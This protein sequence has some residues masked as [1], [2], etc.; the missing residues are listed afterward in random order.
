MLVGISKNKFMKEVKSLIFRN[1]TKT[2]NVFSRQFFNY[3]LDNSLL[4]YYSDFSRNWGDF[5]N[6]TLINELQEKEVVS[7][8]RIYNI[9]KKPAVFGIGSILN[10]NLENAVIWGSGFI[11]YPQQVQKPPKE[12]LA[13][14]GKLTAGYFEKMGVPHN[15]VYGD[16]ALLLPT[17]YN[18]VKEKKF[19]LG[20]VPH[21]TEVNYFMENKFLQS[22]KDIKIITPMVEKDKPYEIIDEVLECEHIISSSLHGLIL[23]DAYKIPSARFRFQ[24]KVIGDDFKFNDYYSGVG[25]SYYNTIDISNLNKINAGVIL[26]ETELKKIKFDS[27]ALKNSLLEYISKK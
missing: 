18:P 26:K 19:R 24:K 11:Q 1:Y 23:A 13:L 9:K 2:K 7:F 20:I 16:P 14:R 15:N 27:S 22:Q 6:P 12:I 5:I 10:T 4:V 8:K 25:V 3:L 17:I 21:Y